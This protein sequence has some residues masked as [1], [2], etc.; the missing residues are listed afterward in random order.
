MHSQCP[1]QSSLIIDGKRE[2]MTS[3]LGTNAPER[4]RF[5]KEE[6]QALKAVAVLLLI[7]HHTLRFPFLYDGYA[8]NFFPLVESQ[9][10]R[11]SEYSKICVG[12]FAFI[13][14]YGITKKYHNST[15]TVSQQAIIQY[16][17]TIRSFWP[18]FILALLISACANGKPFS[19]YQADHLLQSI[20]YVLLDGF[21]LA[22][23]MGTPMLTGSWWYLS[24]VVIF[25]FFTPIIRMAVKRLGW[26]ASAFLLVAFPRL[27]N[28]GF[29]GDIHPVSFLMPLF[30]GVLFAEYNIFEFFAR[31]RLLKNNCLNCWLRRIICTLILLV[32]YK[33]YHYLPLN[34]VWEYHY[35]IA[36][37]VFILT[38]LEWLPLFSPLKGIL[39][40]LG[41]H[42]G[43]IYFV[44]DFVLGFRGFLYS[45]PW[46]GL[47][48]VMVYAISLCCSLAL[49]WGKG[50]LEMQR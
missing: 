2:R 35:G 46:F 6:S 9:V 21:G 49:E 50:M 24:A 41:R 34:L 7:V 4:N 10:N 39:S 20:L 14:G 22:Q 48:P 47:I 12:I 36:P 26:T 28:M 31:I 29:P 18:V 44:H 37:V 25:L 27:L 1:F 30:F 40:R 45:M 15:K 32:S 38:F 19:I 42:S 8:I 23:L 16:F 43:N 17:N 3:V 11:I 5:T 13:T 33:G